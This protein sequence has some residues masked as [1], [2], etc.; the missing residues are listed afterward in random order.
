MDIADH[1]ID[2]TL[3][4]TGVAGDGPALFQTL[5]EVG[6]FNAA[7]VVALVLEDVFYRMEDVFDAVMIG[8]RF[9]VEEMDGHGRKG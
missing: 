3:V 2:G 1:V 8:H 9:A 6:A 5:A 7:G 4:L